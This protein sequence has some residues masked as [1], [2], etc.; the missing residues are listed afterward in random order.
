MVKKLL[1]ITYKIMNMNIKETVLELD[2]DLDWLFNSIELEIE[3]TMPTRVE[4]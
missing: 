4:K 1:L 3:R 2:P